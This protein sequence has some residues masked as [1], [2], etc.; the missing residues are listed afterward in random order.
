MKIVEFDFR[1]FRKQAEL[2]KSNKKTVVVRIRH[3][4]KSKV[5]TIHKSKRKVTD[6]E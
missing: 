3:A 6:I 1:G 4:G 2:I 5:A